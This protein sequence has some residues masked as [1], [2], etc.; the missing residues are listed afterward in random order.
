MRSTINLE[1]KGD[2]KHGNESSP[3]TDKS[4]VTNVSTRITCSGRSKL[5]GNSAT[6]KDQL[7]HPSPSAVLQKITGIVTRSHT[8][9]DDVDKKEPTNVEKRTELDNKPTG[10]IT[11]SQNV[12]S[13]GNLSQPSV[14]KNEAG[15]MRTRSQSSD[16]SENLSKAS[17]NLDTTHDAT[18][19]V[20]VSLLNLNIDAN[21]KYII[22]PLGKK[23][24]KNTHGDN[25]PTISQRK[26]PL[27]MYQRTK[28]R[29]SPLKK[30]K[31]RMIPE[32]TQT[33]TTWMRWSW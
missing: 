6:K 4:A 25:T 11:R 33:H 15:R 29:R 3:S 22:S 17:K 27:T 13:T 24:N 21:K 32:M 1:L 23:D 2:T 8:K 9:E 16:K 7:D 10:R 12:M 31:N 30:T 20:M 28:D 19:D 26:T 5:S 18:M 14:T